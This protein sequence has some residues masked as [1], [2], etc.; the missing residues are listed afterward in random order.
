M[1]TMT[2]TPSHPSLTEG[3]SP[4]N[5]T[6]TNGRCYPSADL[7]RHTIRVWEPRLGR[8]LTEEDARQIL[9][10]VVGYY[11]VSVVGYYRVLEVWDHKERDAISAA[12]DIDDAGK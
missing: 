12:K 8:P 6:T 10:S 3:Q 1:A 9:N 4:E 5:G 11:R 2:Q 7:I